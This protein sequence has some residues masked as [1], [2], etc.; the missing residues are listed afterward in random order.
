[1]SCFQ[2]S[3]LEPV[4]DADFFLPNV[5]TNPKGTAVRG[6]H[7]AV[8]K[9]DVVGFGLGGPIARESKLSTESEH[10]AGA[11]R[12]RG[13]PVGWER[14]GRIGAKTDPPERNRGTGRGSVTS[15]R[16]FFVGPGTAAL[17]I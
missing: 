8:A 16:E 1:M 14:A 4:I 11:M 9:A 15:R 3:L 7:V 6:G 10:P 12:I 13:E 2:L 5:H 17:H